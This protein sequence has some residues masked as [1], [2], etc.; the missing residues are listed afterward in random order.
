MDT[1]TLAYDYAKV[2]S[3]H[4]PD[5]WHT[6]KKA[7]KDW[8][9]GF[10]KKNSS[11][12]IRTPQATSLGRTTSFNRHNVSE[13]FTKLS[14]VYEQY[15]FGCQDIWNIDETGV[16]TVQRPD[17]IIAS[18]GIK[19]V[20]AATSGETGS[21]VTLVYAVSACRN[22]VPPLLIFP[23]KY[24]KEHFVADGPPGCI[25]SANPSGWVT[26]EE[27]LLFIKHFVKHTKYSKEHPVL[28]V[29]DNLASHLSVNIVVKMVLFFCH[30]PL[31]RHT[32]YSHR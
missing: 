23:R 1:K 14:R 8:L 12:S 13:F 22:S 2:N 5:N 31:I 29:L 26:S 7:S 9:I 3:V 21:L 4:V 27:F 18:K 16:T 24:F 19:Q 10:L 15:K 20:G 11:L 6:N 30:F 25:G 28:I 32:N 17:K